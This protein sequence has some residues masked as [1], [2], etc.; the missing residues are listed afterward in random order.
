M[1]TTP[2]NS[3]GMGNGFPLCPQ[4]VDVSGYDMWITLGGTEKG[5][6]PTAAEIALSRVNAMNLFWNLY[7]V[8]LTATTNSA[9]TIISDVNAADDL[10]LGNELPRERVC[11]G[12][13]LSD[14]TYFD[15]GI[16]DF[17]QDAF[18]NF[19]TTNC[20]VRMVN[21]DGDFLGYGINSS[22]VIE[23][24]ISG[25]AGHLSESPR[26]LWGSFICFCVFLRG[27]P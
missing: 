27:Y 25:V 17:T 11:S 7:Q 14:S 10:A 13:S 20:I 2:F 15:F 26:R 21:A 19:Y 4:N 1:L 8:N 23:D 6:V 18:T 12:V 5:S 3:L 16:Q 22:T 24:V 9:G